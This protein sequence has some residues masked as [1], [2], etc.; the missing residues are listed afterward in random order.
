MLNEQNEKWTIQTITNAIKVL[1]NNEIYRLGDGIKFKKTHKVRKHILENPKYDNTILKIFYQDP[2]TNPNLYKIV[3]R[4]K[5]ILNFVPFGDDTLIVHIRSGDDLLK[6]GL[7]NKK[8]MDFFVHE[9]NKSKCA[10]VKI[11]TALHY[12]H[13]NADDSLYKCRTFIY[14][15]INHTQNIEKIYELISK[16]NKPVG[17]ISNENVDVDTVNLV[18]CRQLLTSNETGAFS[19]MVKK[20]QNEFIS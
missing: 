12:G 19:K 17:I 15:E 10:R 1:K 18:F 16:L 2:S 14:K 9:I 7:G 5:N 6:R 4:K 13:S 20:L 3:E 8:N 11:V